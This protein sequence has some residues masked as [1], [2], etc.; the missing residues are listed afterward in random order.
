M[1]DLGGRHLE[2]RVAVGRGQAVAIGEVDLE[3]TVRIL[4]IDLVDIEARGKQ[5]GDELLHEFARADE[6]FVVVA[7]LVESIGSVDRRERAVRFALEQHEFRLDTGV[8]RPSER[9]ELRELRLQRHPRAVLVRLAVDMAIADDARI[10]GHPRDERQRRK[11][12]DRHVFGAMRTHA[13]APDREPR[14]S[15]AGSQ[16]VFEMRG[17]DTLCLRRAVNVDELRQDE[18][19]LVSPEKFPCIDQRHI[20][21]VR[22]AECLT[23]P[24]N[25]IF[26]IRNYLFTFE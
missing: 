13:E 19:D 8:H 18:L 10:A 17:R 24:Q 5:R 4:M 20:R 3:L 11:I 26:H 23:P 21:L 6:P 2:Q 25:P 7:G 22:V 14:K 1:R 15:R 12:A 16:Q 9:I